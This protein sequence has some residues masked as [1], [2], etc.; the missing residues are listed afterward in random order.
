MPLSHLISVLELRLKT[1]QEREEHHPTNVLS[2][3]TSELAR[4]LD[5]LKADRDAQDR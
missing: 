1:L 4:T 2:G 5:L 3:R